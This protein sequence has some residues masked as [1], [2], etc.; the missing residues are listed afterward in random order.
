MSTHLQ[1]N[2]EQTQ[3]YKEEESRHSHPH[4]QDM[5]EMCHH[6]HLFF[7]QIQMMDGSLHEGII[8]DADNEGVTLLMPFE[9]DPH[10]D[11]SRQFGTGVGGFGTFSPY[12]FG[13]GPG[14]GVPWR[15]RRFRRRRF[16]FYGIGG[17]YFPFFI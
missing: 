11:A 14:Y 3:G 2:Q 13:Y 7:V 17:F 16:P 15:F 10:H 5:K 9:Q 12:G 6:Y 8:E 1:N 4:E